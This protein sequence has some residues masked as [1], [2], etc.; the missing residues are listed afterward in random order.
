M[1][2][3][4]NKTTKQATKQGSPK[5]LK[6]T[7]SAQDRPILS[8]LWLFLKGSS[9]GHFILLVLSV[10]FLLLLDILLAAN[11]FDRFTLILGLELLVVAIALW[12]AYLWRH[13]G[14]LFE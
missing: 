12:I 4:A 2:N 13:R 9:L 3:K 14:Q 6:K 10:I 11:Q 1:P 8:L 5:T 7:L